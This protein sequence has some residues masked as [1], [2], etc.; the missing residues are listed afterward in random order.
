MIMD[1]NTLNKIKFMNPGACEVSS[2]MSDS[3]QP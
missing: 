1:Y 2:V 3:L